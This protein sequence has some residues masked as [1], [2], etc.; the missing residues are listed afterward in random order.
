MSSPVICKVA[1]LQDYLNKYKDQID[2][3]G[4]SQEFNNVMKSIDFVYN[5]LGES[6]AAANYL[7]DRAIRM[8]GGLKIPIEAKTTDRVFKNVILKD[9]KNHFGREDYSLDAINFVFA[10]DPFEIQAKKY[11]EL[12]SQS[13]MLRFIKRNLL[14]A[15]YCYQQLSGEENVVKTQQIEKWLEAL[16]TPLKLGYA[17]EYLFAY[18]QNHHV[19]FSVQHPRFFE[20]IEDF[21]K[22]A[23]DTSSEEVIES[24]IMKWVAE[25]KKTQESIKIDLNEKL[26]KIEKGVKGLAD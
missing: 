20:V 11:V 21:C 5:A 16:K 18:F 6:E 3:E 2:K 9:L 14:S 10:D 15:L 4:Q 22:I 7:A 24:N 13:F 19:S 26:E 1:E 8:I 23:N 17:M 25:L 12:A